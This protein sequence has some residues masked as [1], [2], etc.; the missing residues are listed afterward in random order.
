MSGLN[1]TRPTGGHQVPVPTVAD[2]V[3]VLSQLEHL[4]RAFDVEPP[5]V[6]LNHCVTGGLGV[7]VAL[8][9]KWT[10]GT[11]FLLGEHG[12]YLRERFLSLKS[13][14]YSHHVRSLMLRFVVRLTELSYRAADLIVPVC[15]YNGGWEQAVGGS[16]DKVRAIHNGIETSRFGEPPPEPEH[17]TLVWV[18]R[19]DPIKD[20]E[21]LI[22]AFAMVLPSVPDARLRIFGPPTDPAYAARCHELTAE[23]GATDSIAF[24]GRLEPDAVA[25]AY[26]SGQV[27]A[28]TSISEGF[29]YAVLEA[30][31]AG[32]PVV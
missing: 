2:A 29:P 10:R 9:G 30:M 27:I 26:H 6:D 16:M 31:A 28:L 1:P 24:E 3:D 15:R 5:S 18:G 22:R 21:T 4:L 17:P 19:I 8:A 12:L 25:A 23:L 32:R 20:V 14:V 7:L 13:G 11:P